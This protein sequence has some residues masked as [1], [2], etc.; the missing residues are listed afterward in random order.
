[1]GARG[2]PSWVC[3]AAASLSWD[4]GHQ[5]M[6]CVVLVQGILSSGILDRWVLSLHHCCH[7]WLTRFGNGFC[8]A[9][10]LSCEMDSSA[11]ASPICWTGGSVNHFYMQ[12]VVWHRYPGSCLHVLWV[13]LY[14]AHGARLRRWTRGS[15]PRTSL[16]HG[17]QPSLT[18]LPWRMGS[19]Q[20][21]SALDSSV[22]VLPTALC[23]MP[24][25]A[26]VGP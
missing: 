3:P 2:V 10:A 24:C 18:P 9:P 12:Q 11:P 22:T 13:P 5:E 21:A 26:L 23:T 17:A 19:S 16:C 7:S 25:V 8:R 4:A 15:V 6:G 1:M 20:G 14:R